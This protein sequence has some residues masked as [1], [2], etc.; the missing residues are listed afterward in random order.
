MSIS[1]RLVIVLACVAS[2][3]WVGSAYASPISFTVPLT[4]AEQVPPVETPAKGSAAVTY[5]PATRV[6]T[7]TITYTGLSAPA[8][9]AHF[10]GPAEKGKNAPVRHLAVHEG[11]SRGEPFQRRGDANAGAGT[12]VHRRRVVHKRAHA[13]ASGRRNPRPGRAAQEL[14]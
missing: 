1:R 2:A 4:G 6:V 14:I 5:D 3:A 9:M 7:W 10:H 13:S 8:T 11:Q 12:A